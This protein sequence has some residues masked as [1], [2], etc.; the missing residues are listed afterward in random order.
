MSARAEHRAAIITAIGCDAEALEAIK[1]N[2]PL[3]FSQRARQVCAA[4]S[5]PYTCNAAS[6]LRT[7]L[8]WCKESTSLQ[9]GLSRAIHCR[10]QTKMKNRAEKRHF[11]RRLGLN[12]NSGERDAYLNLIPNLVVSCLPSCYPPKGKCISESA[13]IF[14]KW[15]RHFR[16]ARQPDSRKP[17]PSIY[18]LQSSNLAYDILPTENAALRN[19]CG[20][21]VGLIIRNFCPDSDIVSWVENVIAETLPKRKN[22]RVSVDIFSLQKTNY[23]WQ[24]EDP[25]KLVQL[26]YSAGARSQPSFHWVRNIVLRNLDAAEI[27]DNDRKTSSVFAFAWQLMRNRLPPEIMQDFDVFLQSSQ[28]KRMDGNGS[29]CQSHG[30]IQGTYEVSIGRKVFDFC[31]AE[32]AP[33][34]GVF[35]TNY[36]R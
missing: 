32:L 17:R 23:G 1:Q 7:F 11:I 15:D 36:S 22:I 35:G 34:A 12:W 30:D 14:Q 13:S 24:M 18:T 16:T 9:P 19:S 20:E 26:G 10:A 29:M 31:Q 28:L 21:L 8:C 27:A 3:K 6:S 33:P 2:I 4:S 25:G 5:L